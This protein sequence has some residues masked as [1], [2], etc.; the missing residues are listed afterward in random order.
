MTGGLAFLPQPLLAATEKHGA[1]ALQRL[2]ERLTI[3]VRHHEY[4]AGVG[5]LHDGRDEAVAFLEIDARDIQGCAHS[6]ISMPDA[7][8]VVLRS[9]IA[10]APEWNTLAASAASTDAFSKTSTKCWGAPA[11]PDATSGTSQTSRTAFSCA[12]S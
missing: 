11:P 1:L 9:G 12:T 5:V 2:L 4:G 6:R 10:M 8:S 7:A 3:H